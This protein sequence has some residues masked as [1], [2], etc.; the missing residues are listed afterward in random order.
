MRTLIVLTVSLL[1]FAAQADELSTGQLLEFCTSKDEMVQ[2]ACRYFILG[3]GQGVGAG[4]GIV[5]SGRKF[6]E[7]TKT[8]FCVPDVIS[9]AKSC[10]KPRPVSSVPSHDPIPAALELGLDLPP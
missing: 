9:R 10:R 6:T 2:T 8:H 5:L 7:R 1:S 3:V 4:D